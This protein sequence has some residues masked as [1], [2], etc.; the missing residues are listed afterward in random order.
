MANFLAIV[1]ARMS[2][3][4]LPGK[5]MMEV[6][7]TPLIKILVD[8]V[9]KSKLINDVVVS[10][11]TNNKDDILV[12]YLKKKKIKFFRGSE[13]NV[14]KRVI[15]TA[16][17]L[18]SKNIILITGDCPLIDFNL[19]DQCIRTFKSNNVQLVTNANIRSY[20]DGMDVQ[21]FKTRTLINFYNNISNKKEFEHVTLS[22]RRRIAKD[23]IINIIAP[24]NI[25]FPKIGL[26]I[27][28]INDLKLIKKIINYFKSKN[29]KFFTCQ[30][31]LKYLSSNKNLLN[32]NK[33][34][35]RKG[36]K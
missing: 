21:V 7:N 20:P 5:V 34:V 36:D 30:E 27:D 26:T 2:S 3:S 24:E 32:I 33:F 29:N 13:N 6:N 35:K 18:K 19:M 16:K 17:N 25:R 15:E 31:I 1:T 14:T 9:K 8:R 10:T 22:I 12:N 4:R 23:Q 11:T 28:E